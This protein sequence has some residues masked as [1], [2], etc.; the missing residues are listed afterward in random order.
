MISEVLG[1]LLGT[2]ILLY[3]GGAVIAAN[4]LRKTKS[5]GAGWLVIIFGWGLAVMFASLVVGFFSPAYLNPAIVFAMVVLEEISLI[6]AFLFIIAEFLGAMFGA[7][8]VWLH[9]YPHWEQTTDAEAIFLFLQQHLPLN[10]AYLTFLQKLWG[11]HF[12]FWLY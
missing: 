9:Y 10:I 11:Q 4:V 3:L 2:A 8:L 1:E 12:L 6:S 7:F 5:E